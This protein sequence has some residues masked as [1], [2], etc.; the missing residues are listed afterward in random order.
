MSLRLKAAITLTLLFLVCGLLAGP[1]FLSS[2]EERRDAARFQ[3]KIDLADYLADAARWQAIERGMGEAIL[4]GDSIMVPGFITAGKMADD[5][6]A[7]AR[8]HA[9]QLKGGHDNRAVNRR[10]E[11]WSKTMAEQKAARELVLKRDISE[12]DWISISN[13]NIRDADLVLWD[14]ANTPTDPHDLIRYLHTILL[15]N[16]ALMAEYAGLERAAIAGAIAGNQV[17]D[18]KELELLKQYRSIMEHSFRTVELV[19]SLQRTPL[20]VKLALSTYEEEFFGRYEILRQ[21]IYEESARTT[22]VQIKA[23]ELRI[24]ESEKIHKYFAG[25]RYDMEGLCE[26]PIIQD[27]GSMADRDSDSPVL[28][29]VEQFLLRFA[30]TKKGIYTQ[31][32]YLHRDGQE[33]IRTDSDGQ[34]VT[35]QS[36]P[37]LQDKSDRP[38]FT[39]TIGLPPGEFYTSPLELNIEYGAVVRPFKPVV[40]YAKQVPGPDGVSGVIVLKVFTQRMLDSIDPRHILIDNEG[41]YLSHPDK[42]KRWGMM[43]SL[44]RLHDNLIADLG[45]NDARMLLRGEIDQISAGGLTLDSE[46]VLIHEGRVETLSWLLLREREHPHYGLSVSEWFQVST[47]AI[48][49]GLAIADAIAAMSE[50][51]SEDLAREVEQRFLITVILI[52]VALALVVIMGIYLTRWIVHGVKG[53]VEAMENLSAGRPHEH[54]GTSRGD[55]I[56]RML[57]AVDQFA[58]DLQEARASLSAHID[59][60]SDAREEAESANRIKSEFLA[61]MSHE[62]R[63]PMNGVIGMT[64]LL[65]DSELDAE[66]RDFSECALTSAESLMTIINDILDF[67]KVEAGKIELERITFDLHQSLDAVVDLMRDRAQK[68]DLELIVD[69]G[70]DTPRKVVGDP[71]RI[72]QILVNIVGNAVKFTEEGYV[73]IRACCRDQRPGQTSFLIEVVDTGIGIDPEILPILFEKFTQ[74]DASMSRR[75]GGTGLGLAICRQLANLMNGSVSATSEMGKGSVF[76]L[77]LPL[78]IAA[79]D[80]RSSR[81]PEIAGRRIL[82]ADSLAPSRHAL[83]A[84]L[85]QLGLK[86]VTAKTASG[87]GSALEAAL[88]EGDPLDMALIAQDLSSMGGCESVRALRA[89]DR[90]VDL[91]IIILGSRPC[92]DQQELTSELGLSAWLPKP[93]SIARLD[94][95][96]TKVLG[97]GKEN[98][99]RGKDSGRDSPE[100]KP[101]FLN[102]KLLLVEDNMINQKLAVHLLSRL[103]CKVDVAANGQEAVDKVK[104]EPYDMIFMDCQMP[105]MDGYQAT[106]AIRLLDDE[107]AGIPIIAMTANAMVGDREIC[108]EAGMNDYMAKPINP[109]TLT[110]CLTHWLRRSEEPGPAT[111]ESLV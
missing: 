37:M 88:E 70:M 5:D 75:F 101:Q 92:D 63:T 49:S 28:A 9:M 89:D 40:R 6:V 44:D 54:I 55:E 8:E 35:L 83:G 91:P 69:W 3:T 99:R 79:G 42:Y 77:E 67:S 11:L 95:A 62:I 103:G 1:H 18:P 48:D 39:E 86:V 66:Q 23:K 108:L 17:L 53:V 45:V 16:I 19:K 32:S 106:V 25:V 80:S 33:W 102:T 30:Q 72:R 12:Q 78:T 65:L 22:E 71:G 10:L 46:F 73:L 100:R 111:K 51:L 26:L 93:V 41:F 87:V 76:S 85:T 24:R 7:I 57:S 68:K 109:E 61:S 2:I 38:Y 81:N 20:A 90:F 96:L 84:S 107:R 97:S 13:R 82:L 59:E 27:L 15:P 104:T 4:A 64:R 74:A 94:R 14:I 36:T 98:A 105:I 52:G 50:S 56:G 110:S 34:N 47:Q 31:V 58:D 21:S 43:P 29:E 60:L